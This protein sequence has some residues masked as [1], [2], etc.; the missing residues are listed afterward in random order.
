MK[1][2]EGK[3]SSGRVESAVRGMSSAKLIIMMSDEKNFEGNVKKLEELYPGVPSIGCVAM[4]YDK[5]ICETGVVVAGF[6]EGVQVATNVLE[7]VS[8]MPARYIDRLKHDIDTI[9]PGKENT[10]IF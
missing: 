10:A 5:A 6:T 3:D 7:K 8:K 9:R 2:F 4:G 1:M